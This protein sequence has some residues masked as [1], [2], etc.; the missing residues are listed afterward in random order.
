M[1]L[2]DGSKHDVVV[3]FEIPAGDFARARRFYEEVFGA[4]VQPRIARAARE[5]LHG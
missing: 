1:A 2:T 3:W 5:L 4:I